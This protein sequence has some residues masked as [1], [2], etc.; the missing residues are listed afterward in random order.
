MGCLGARESK[1]QTK[2]GIHFSYF[3]FKLKMVFTEKGS[4]TKKSLKSGYF[5]ANCC[6]NRFLAP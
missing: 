3:S 2:V 5:Y 4:Q 6:L 1:S